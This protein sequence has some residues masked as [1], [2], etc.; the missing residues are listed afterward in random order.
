MFAWD[1]FSD[2]KR[3]L[4]KIFFC[5]FVL[6]QLRISS[7]PNHNPGEPGIQR[8][9]VSNATTEEQ[10]PP[11]HSKC[12]LGSLFQTS[13]GFSKKLVSGFGHINHISPNPNSNL[14]PAESGTHRQRVNDA[15]Q[16]KRAHQYTQNVRL[17]SFLKRQ[18]GFKKTRLSLWLWLYQPHIF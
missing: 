5:G 11:I 17:G 16:K 4:K 12:T 14:N 15:T 9:M 6:H 3:V 18:N 2:I 7:N 8:Q 10:G 1:L 13:K